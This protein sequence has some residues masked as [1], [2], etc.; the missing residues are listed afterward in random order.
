MFII[1]MFALIVIKHKKQLQYI[2]QLW[3]TLNVVQGG[4]NYLW[5]G[6]AFLW[7]ML[8]WRSKSIYFSILWTPFMKLTLQLSHDHKKKIQ[9]KSHN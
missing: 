1:S 7:W 5:H 9:I 2:I 4:T 8:A 3:Y 6:K